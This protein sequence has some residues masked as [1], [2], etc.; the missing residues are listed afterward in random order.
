MIANILAA[1]CVWGACLAASPSA[2]ETRVIDGDTIIVNDT[3]VRLKGLSCDELG[4]NDGEWQATVLQT[5]FSKA[6]EVS[7]E[8]TGE[9]TYNREVGW[10]SLDGVDIGET[11]ISL[12]SCQPCRRYDEGGKYDHLPI[13]GPVPK[14]C[15]R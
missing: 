1:T 4:T 8:L 14:Y 9:K 7:C 12:T 13:T 11:M 15:K 6:Q 10:C 5:R 2:G 3:R